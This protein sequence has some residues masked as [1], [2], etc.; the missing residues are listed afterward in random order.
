MPVDTRPI[1]MMDSGVGGLSIL[2]EVR[3]QLPNEDV[4]YFADQGHVP[5]GPRP[6]E[7]IIQFLV[8]IT[9]FFQK[10]NAKVIVI[11]CNTASA[12]GLYEIRKLFPD[13]TYVGMEP[14]VKPAV[15]SA[16]R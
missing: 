4:I 15:A 1:A 3:R 13:I 5:Y 16:S 2:R 8:G 11:A 14:A 12:A 6:Q 9:H 10:H 7:E